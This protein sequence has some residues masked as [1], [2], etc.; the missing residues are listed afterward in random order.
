MQFSLCGDWNVPPSADGCFVF[1]VTIVFVERKKG[2]SCI[3][4]INRIYTYP[5]KEKEQKSELFDFISQ[6][7][8]NDIIKID[9][10][11]PVAVY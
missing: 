11:S 8:I 2:K 5:R 6:I 7:C 3:N 9:K 4:H 1:R 10:F